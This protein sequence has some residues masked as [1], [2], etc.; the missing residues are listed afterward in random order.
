MP[1]CCFSLGWRSSLAARRKMCQPMAPRGCQYGTRRCK[2]H[3]LRQAMRWNPHRPLE[4]DHSAP[5]A[6][7]LRRWLD[8]RP[9][10]QMCR[11]PELR[12][13]CSSH[14]WLFMLTRPWMKPPCTKPNCTYR[15]RLVH[16]DPYF[17]AYCKPCI[18]MGSI[19]SPGCFQK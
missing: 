17:M 8:W 7:L 15:R 10:V 16:K 9:M 14:S 18:M 6:G 12:V 5:T 3:E 11:R 1:R 13:L 2:G 19:S 4:T